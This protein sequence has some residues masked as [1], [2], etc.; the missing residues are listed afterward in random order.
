MKPAQPP[1]RGAP[2][3][4]HALPMQTRLAPVA[5][6]EAALGRDGVAGELVGEGGGLRLFALAGY[7]QRED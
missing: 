2:T 4:A 7:Y 5:A 1:S 6:I 3:M